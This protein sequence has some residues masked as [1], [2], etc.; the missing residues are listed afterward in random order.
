MIRI[1]ITISPQG[2]TTLETKGTTGPGCKEFSR[3]L[4]CALG[5]TLGE[6]LSADYFVAEATRQQLREET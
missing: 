1:E 2:A 6:Q 4:E 5:R 3:F